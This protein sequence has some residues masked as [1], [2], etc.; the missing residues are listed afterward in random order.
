M[1][2]ITPTP[3][4]EPFVSTIPQVAAVQQVIADLDAIPDTVDGL[5]LR[6]FKRMAAA[7]GSTFI[8]NLTAVL[9]LGTP[10]A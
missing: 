4:E 8:T 5:D 3:S 10:A 1:T 6:Q 2:E 7:S 9:K